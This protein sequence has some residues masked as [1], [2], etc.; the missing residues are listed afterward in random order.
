MRVG[1]W[2]AGF[3]LPAALCG[4]VERKLLVR[5]DPPGAR[6]Y[7]DGRFRGT[8]GAG[9]GELSVPFEFYGS[10]R[11][12]LRAEG[13]VPHSGRVELAPPW[14][15]WFPLDLFVDVLWP[16]TVE[17]THE[18]RVD[19]ERR[20]SPGPA[21]DVEA[22]ARAFGAGGASHEPSDQPDDE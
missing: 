3:L 19:L 18:V 13:Y 21:A 7:L 8:T 4:C 12:V 10:R 20:G 14:W 1:V 2:L 6:V 17:D 11:L 15:Q 9:A 16:G 5:S 22:R